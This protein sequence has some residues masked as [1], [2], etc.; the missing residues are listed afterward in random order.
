MKTEYTISIYLIFQHLLLVC[1]LL[2]QIIL[3]NILPLPSICIKVEYFY[4][5]VEIIKYIV[6]TKC[7]HL[8]SVNTYHDKFAHFTKYYFTNA[9]VSH[10]SKKHHHL[11]EFSS[12]NLNYSWF[13]SYCF[14]CKFNPSAVTLLYV[15]LGICSFPLVSSPNHLSSPNFHHCSSE[16]LEQLPNWIHIFHSLLWNPLSPQYPEIFLNQKLNDVISPT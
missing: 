5:C 7:F 3:V 9:K 16:F 10:F 4:N 12:L 13:H 8:Q 15:Y 1:I 11:P 2:I 14:S 6:I